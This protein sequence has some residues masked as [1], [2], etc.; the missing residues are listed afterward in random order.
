MYDETMIQP[1]REEMTGAG[2]QEI[3][4]AENVDNVLQEPGTTLFFINSVCG[5]A[6]GTARPGIRASL[7]HSLKPDRLVTSFAGNDGDAVNRAR[8]RFV[9]YPPSSPCAALIRDG[10]VVHMVERHDI[11][12]RNAETVAK[13]LKRAYD[14]YCGQEID[15]SA[16]VYDPMAAL[17]ISQEDARDKSAATFL[18]VREPWEI[19]QGMIEGAVRVD[20]AMAQEIIDSWPREKE[21]IVYCQHGQRSLQAAQFF[22]THGFENVKSLNGGFSAW[23]VAH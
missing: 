22:Q 1:M 18:D 3:R 9:G 17:Q 10:Q 4:T 23:S 20:R 21:L 19:D 6:A 2:F 16:E 5:C 15:D 14:K 8:Q 11:E 13:I 7:E 12:G